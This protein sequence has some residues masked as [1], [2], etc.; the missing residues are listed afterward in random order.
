[1]TDEEYVRSAEQ[2]ADSARQEYYATR[3]SEEMRALLN[4]ATPMSDAHLDAIVSLF[5]LALDGEGT[6]LGDIEA[7]ALRAVLPLVGEV[8]RLQ[9][10]SAQV[11][12]LAT[13][14]QHLG[15]A[16]ADLALLNDSAD[17]DY[18]PDRAKALRELRARI[19]ALLPPE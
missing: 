16:R 3:R 14:G 11:L 7:H 18:K 12:A 4:A 8:R 5:P 2:A 9:A 1:M 6:Y 17:D 15:F 13:H 19:A 10:L